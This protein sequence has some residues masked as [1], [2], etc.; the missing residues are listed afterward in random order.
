MTIEDRVTFLERRV[1]QLEQLLKVPVHSDELDPK[2]TEACHLVLQYD[3][4]S[5]S[6]IQRRLMIGYARAARILDQLT[7][8]ALISLPKGSKP[9]DVFTDKVEEYLSNL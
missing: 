9:R 5:A 7:E 4:A 8:A 3:K 1:A 2:F 6:M